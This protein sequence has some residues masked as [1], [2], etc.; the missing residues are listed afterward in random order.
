MTIYRTFLL[1]GTINV[2]L[3]FI[4][5]QQA[6]DLQTS[7]SFYVIEFRYVFGAIGILCLC[8]L[9]FYKLLTTS[10]V[11]PHQLIQLVHSLSFTVLS[12][13]FW[14]AFIQTGLASFPRRYYSFN[15]MPSSYITYDFLN[16]SMG[17][18]A[19]FFIF[20]QCVFLI[21]LIYNILWHTFQKKANKADIK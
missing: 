18:S 4:P 2:L 16:V 12:V 10:K 20:V 1:T 15:R 7:D 8:F 3:A 14:I 19:L 13:T 17:L 21:T 6:F 5:S 11:L 9:G